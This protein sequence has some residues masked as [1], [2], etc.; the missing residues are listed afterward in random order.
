MKATKQARDVHERP[1]GLAHILFREGVEAG[2]HVEL[3]IEDEVEYPDNGVDPHVE[4]ISNTVPTPS[5]N[6]RWIMKS[7]FRAANNNANAHLTDGQ[8][9]SGS[10]H[11]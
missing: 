8:Q 3:G 10:S 9:H 5:G 4:L 2:N 6:R 1:L 7:S 11:I